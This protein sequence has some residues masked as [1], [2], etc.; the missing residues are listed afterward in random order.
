[1]STINCGFRVAKRCKTLQSRSHDL[2]DDYYAIGSEINHLSELL[3]CTDIPQAS[4]FYR[5]LADLIFKQ[6]DYTLYQGEI[7]QQKLA[8][9]FKY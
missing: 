8:G 4:T 5:R 1:M 7:M 9:W 2:A 3:K 6:G